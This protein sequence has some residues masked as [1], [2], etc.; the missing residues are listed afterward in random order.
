MDKASRISDQKMHTMRARVEKVGRTISRS[1]DNSALVANSVL[2]QA[3][4]MLGRTNRQADQAR[5]PV[6]SARDKVLA[7]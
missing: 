5:G 3:L 6:R 7:K 1:L 2:D 4:D